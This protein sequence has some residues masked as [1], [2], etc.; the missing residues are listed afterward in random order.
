MIKQTIKA[1][2]LILWLGLMGWWWLE[3]RTWPTP[4]KLDLAFLPNY[5]D[6]FSLNNGEQKIGWA[7]KNIRRNLDGS[8]Q[9][10][11]GVTVKI[12]IA[13]Q[14]L[15]ITAEVMANFS[16][17]LNLENFQYVVKSGQVVIGEAGWVSAGQLTVDVSLGQYEDSF[18]ALREKYSHLLGE[19]ADYFDFQ[20]PAVLPV[21]AG[22]ALPQFI[23]AY[24][25]H[26]ELEV[27]RNYS[28]NVLNPLTRQ[29]EILMVRVEEETG[30]YD[31][32]VGRKVPI[33]RIRLGTGDQFSL[34]WTDRF[35]RVLREK[36]FGLSLTRVDT[37][38]EAR[39]GVR[40]LVPPS[41]FNQFLPLFSGLL[42][43]EKGEKGKK[44]KSG[45][46][47]VGKTAIP[48]APVQPERLGEK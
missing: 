31:P 16:K 7:Y 19:Y 8:Y 48:E 21:P 40:P 44:E 41:S 24:L 2:I 36:A 5:Y 6:H 45:Q 26:L 46:G 9:G 34:V 43:W 38:T 14:E 33:F 30:E 20:K 32:K 47:F 37:E 12:K 3:S 13:E 35:G 28:L 23:P 22:P 29:P 11:Q 42:F 18:Q 17:A 1:T 25:G 39:S 15:E 10:L 27:G 4:E